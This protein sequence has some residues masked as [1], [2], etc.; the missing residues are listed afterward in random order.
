MKYEYKKGKFIKNGHTMFEQDVLQD[1]KRLAF[2]EDE[3]TKQLILP[4]VI[5]QSE[6]LKR[7]EVLSYSEYKEKWFEKKEGIIYLDKLTTEFVDVN[8]ILNK[9]QEYCNRL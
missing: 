6:Q 2:L 1:L 4:K 9:Y 8:V 3:K 5:R 7:K